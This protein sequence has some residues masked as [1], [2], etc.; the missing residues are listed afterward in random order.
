MVPTGQVAAKE[1]DTPILP[2]AFASGDVYVHKKARPTSPKEHC[3]QASPFLKKNGQRLSVPKFFCLE[4][5][6][7]QGLPPS[8][9]LSTITSETDLGHVP[10]T[11]QKNRSTTW[12]TFPSP[13][14]LS[15]F[16][17]LY[18]CPHLLIPDLICQSEN[19]CEWCFCL[20]L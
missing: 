2:L 18:I 7:I 1:T 9:L 12:D 10:T 8:P 11:Y 16:Q 15:K 5:L 20:P 4:W 3:Q 17:P 13:R 14:C 19:I 6:G